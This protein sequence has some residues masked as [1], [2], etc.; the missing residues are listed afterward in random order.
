MPKASASTSRDGRRHNPLEADILGGSGILRSGKPGKKSKS[1]SEKEEEHYVNSKQSAAILQLGREL[2]DEDEE[3]KAVAEPQ[4][5]AFD[6]D[7]RFAPGEQE[8]TGRADDDDEDGEAWGDD[9]E[10][11]ELDEADIAPED[12]ATFN[13][14]WSADEEEDPLLKHGFWDRRPDDSEGQQQ[15]QGGTNLA[16]LIMERIQQFESS[17]G[18]RQ[19]MGG[20]DEFPEEDLPPK[21]IEVYAKCGM[22]LSR[23]KSGPL[24]K[25]IKILPTVPD[26]ERIIEVAQPDNWTPNAIFAVTRIF[27][28]SKP[29]VVQ[30]WLEM[31][32]LPRVRDDIYENKKLNVHLY[33]SLKKSLYKPSAFFKGVLF[34]LIESGTCTLREAHIVS[35]V[36]ARVSIPVLHSAAG[37][38][39]LC[40]LAAQQASNGESAASTNVFIKTLLDKGLALPYQV[41]DALVFFFLRFRSV[42][43]AAVKEA[44]AMDRPSW[45]KIGRQ[46]P[47]LWHQCLLSFAQ[48]YR[49]DI[50]EDQR[51]A[52]LDLLLTHGHSAIGPEIRRELIAGRGRGVPVEPQGQA[53]DGDDTMQVD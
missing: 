7:S 26:W 13:K 34:A 42:D 52:L 16:D 46:L 15:Q 27:T 50:N 6:I 51:E 12:L 35:S 3:G 43:P 40:D 53:F 47:V 30:R 8:Q 41:I 48:R 19:E 31:V 4:K 32:V 11:I 37:L 21:V 49:N 2:A 25:P 18:Q 20:M 10:D 44:E 24:P 5:S 23:W 17:G 38:K 45:D 33:N 14:F 29:A 1:K 36:M 28:S 39:G 9:E 22:I